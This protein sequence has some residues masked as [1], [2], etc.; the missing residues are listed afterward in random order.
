MGAFV[1]E[2]LALL[3]AA[4]LAVQ[5]TGWWSILLIPAG[6]IGWFAF[7]SASSIGNARIGGI[8]F[9]LAATIAAAAFAD[10]SARRAWIVAAMYIGSLW[11]ARL[12]YT[13]STTF[14]RLFVL[15]NAKAFDWLRDVFRSGLSSEPPPNPR[16]QPTGRRGRHAPLGHSAPRARC[17]T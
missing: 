17:G 12:L 10:S 8:T 3:G 11:L 16:M 13:S 4:V 15:R 1:G 7:S 2:H 5:V 14:L 9:V 6:L